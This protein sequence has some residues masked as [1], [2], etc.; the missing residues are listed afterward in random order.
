M[1]IAGGAAWF[2]TIWPTINVPRLIVGGLI[3]LAPGLSFVNA[4]HEVAQKN[5]VSGA[6]RLLEAVVTAITL[7]FGVA[8]VLGFARYLERLSN[9]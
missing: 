9:P 5:L 7:A 2:S 6:A 8:A 1:L 3:S 4:L